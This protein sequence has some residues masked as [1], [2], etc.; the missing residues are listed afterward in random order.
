MSLANLFSDIQEVSEELKNEELENKS[1]GGFVTTNGIYKSTIERAYVTAT[2]KGGVQ[3]DLH[4]TGD[5]LINFRLYPVSNKN[6]KKV[7]T[8]TYKGKTQSLQD[9]KML[10][11]IV[12]CATGKG[13]ELEDIKIEEQDIEFKE[14]G[15]AVKLTVGMLTDL[16]GKEIQYGVRCEE[17]YNYEDGETDKTSIKTDDEGNPRYKKVLFSVYSALGKTPIEI[18]KKEDSI[19]L[20]KDKEFLLSDKGIK[21]VKLEAPEFEDGETTIDINDEDIPF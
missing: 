8:Y 6:G 16:V 15:K 1:G 7:T 4:L 18:I 14:Y 20:A 19:Q 11:Q 12:F 17:E 13:Q 5:N 2:K 9:Y 21:R 10:K 3:F